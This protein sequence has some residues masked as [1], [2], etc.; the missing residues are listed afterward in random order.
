MEKTQSA[1]PEKTQAAWETTK[2][3]R[4]LELK[5]EASLIEIDD[6]RFFLQIYRELY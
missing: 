4:K 2:E 3:A 1:D 5:Y 6:M